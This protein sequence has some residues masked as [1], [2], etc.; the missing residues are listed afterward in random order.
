YNAL[1]MNVPLPPNHASNDPML[2]ALT[3][4]T[5][6]AAWAI[7]GGCVVGLFLVGRILR[8]LH[9]RRGADTLTASNPQRFQ[10]GTATMEF[11]LVFPI[12]L[13]F[14]LTLVQTSLLMVGNL[15]VHYAAFASVRSAIVQ[16]PR[17]PVVDPYNSAVNETRN[18]VLIEDS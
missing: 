6:L 5:M 13:F 17:N 18:R 10:A 1:T 15:Y 11:A 7:A 4:S 9:P 16:V 14:I 2:N 12:F 3:S 8:N